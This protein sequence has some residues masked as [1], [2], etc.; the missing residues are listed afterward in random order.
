MR[1]VTLPLNLIESFKKVLVKTT[2]MPTLW[3]YFLW[4]YS[5]VFG[6]SLFGFLIILLST[7][8]EDFARFVTLGANLSA[9]I[10]YVLFQIPYVMQIAL[11]ISSLIATI[12]LFQKLSQNS[13]LTALR[14][15][16]ISLLGVAAPVIIASSLF[17]VITFS[18]LLDMSAYA[19]GAA[20]ELEFQLKSMN[21]IAFIHNSKLLQEGGIS[22]EMKGS[23]MN[24]GHASDVVM[25]LSSQDNSR[26]ALFVAKEMKVED[27]SLRGKN[28]AIITTLE[29]PEIGYYDHLVIENSESNTIKLEDLSSAVN[30]KRLRVGIDHMKFSYLLARKNDLAEQLTE[31]KILSDDTRYMKKLLSKCYSEIARR[32]SLSL[33]IITFALVGVAYGATIGR[34]NAKKRIVKA[35]VLAAFFLVCFLGAKTMDEHRKLTCVLYLAPHLVLMGATLLRFMR[36]QRGVEG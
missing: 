33:A 22:C 21:P 36:I 1:S 24:D 19:H 27:Q 14:A 34:V 8:L 20:K 26:C 10:L 4:Q 32:I 12:F 18:F 11:P 6:L 16:G 35:I 31:K 29:S 3:R 15:S 17:A 2:V 25:A 13:V 28:M 7:R 9:I 23:L 5:K 30:N